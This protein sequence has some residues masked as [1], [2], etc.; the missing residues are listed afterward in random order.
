MCHS[1]ISEEM[2]TA[3]SLAGLPEKFRISSEDSLSHL[4][5]IDTFFKL[6]HYVTFYFLFHLEAWLFWN[7]SQGTGFTPSFKVLFL[8]LTSRTHFLIHGPGANDN[9]LNSKI[10]SNFKARTAAR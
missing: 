8:S 6:I 2:C 3:S 9:D 5:F 10:T 1:G 4:V 7:F